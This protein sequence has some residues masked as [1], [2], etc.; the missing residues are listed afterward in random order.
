MKFITS[1]RKTRKQWNDNIVDTKKALNSEMEIN[2]LM[3]LTIYGILMI[4]VP[5]VKQHH[6]FSPKITR[7]NSSIQLGVM[8]NLSRYNSIR[9]HFRINLVVTNYMSTYEK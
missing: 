4:R 9:K 1:N 5:I 2:I 7:K 3:E 6:S 8:Q